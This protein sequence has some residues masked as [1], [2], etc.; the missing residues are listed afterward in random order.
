MTNPTITAP[1]ASDAG[2]VVRGDLRPIRTR[3]WRRGFVPLL[4]KELGQWWGTRQWVVQALVWLALVN[5][6]IALLMTVD[7]MEDPTQAL[8]QVGM[9][10]TAIGVIVTVQGA[11]VGERQRGTAAWVLSK[12]VSRS[13]FFL[14]KLVAYSIGFAALSLVL[15]WVVYNL[16][17][18]LIA[19]TFPAA[20][21]LLG[22]VGL[23][24]LHLLVYLALV[25]AMGTVFRARGPVA[26]IGIGVLLAGQFFG[27]MV[28]LD[29]R[30]GLPW[31]LPDIAVAVARGQD[32]PVSIPVAVGA[33]LALAAALTGVALWRLAR[34]EL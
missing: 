5:G 2:R 32:V 33:N 10:V 1:A 15:P 30:I 22:A 4:R 13:S 18:R 27:G 12:P 7:P 31:V 26:A 24:G 8:L 29:L 21:P 3:G 19:G 28:P 20:L 14:A 23:W 17:S 16:E 9:L 11:I 25:L 6:V 34:E